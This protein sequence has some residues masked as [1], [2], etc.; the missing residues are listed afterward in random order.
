LVKLKPLSYLSGFTSKTKAK[1]PKFAGYVSVILTMDKREI[2]IFTALLL[3]TA[4]SLYRRYTA[5]KKNEGGMPGGVQKKDDSLTGQPD[6]YE[7][8]SGNK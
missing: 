6:D 5:K 2:I 3:L 4:L 1:I 7:P 8:Y